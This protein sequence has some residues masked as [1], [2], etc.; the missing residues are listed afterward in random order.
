[1]SDTPP[2][3]L[4]AR[5]Q[6]LVDEFKQT[7]AYVAESYVAEV[8]LGVSRSLRRSKRGVVEFSCVN[9]PTELALMHATFAQAGINVESIGDCTDAPRYRLFRASLGVPLV[10]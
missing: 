4:P 2:V 5:L 7:P 8:F 9:L 1:M 6:A 10:L 3:V